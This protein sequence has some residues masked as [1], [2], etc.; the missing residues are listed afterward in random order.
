MKVEPVKVGTLESLLVAFVEIGLEHPLSFRRR[1]VAHHEE[2]LPVGT[3][4]AGSGRCATS[5]TSSTSSAPAASS[6]APRTGRWRAAHF[7]AVW[8]GRIKRHRLAVGGE[9][10][11]PVVAPPLHA[12][13]D[14]G[15]AH[16]PCR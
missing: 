4:H 7:D 8:N 16:A 15:W 10:Q 3:L 11:P 13:P 2:P 12:R 14:A 5:S 9:N 1:H 6:S